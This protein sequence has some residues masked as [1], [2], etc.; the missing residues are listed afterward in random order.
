MCTRCL[1]LLPLEL[2]CERHQA[3]RPKGRQL[4]CLSLNSHISDRSVKK[5]QVLYQSNPAKSQ[6]MVP[7]SHTLKHSLAFFSRNPCTFQHISQHSHMFRMLRTF[8]SNL[9]VR[10]IQPTCVSPNF[11]LRKVHILIYKRAQRMTAQGTTA[12]SLCMCSC[13]RITPS[14]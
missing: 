14:G 2:G 1:D 13:S 11:F 3:K 10:P 6:E 5:M 8:M 7:Q 4:L 12:R 9:A